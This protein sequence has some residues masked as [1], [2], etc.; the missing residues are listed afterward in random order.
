MLNFQGKKKPWYILSKRFPTKWVK[1]KHGLNPTVQNRGPNVL[2]NPN[3]FSL[4]E[5]KTNFEPNKTKQ[6]RAKSKKMCAWAAAEGES[7]HGP[8]IAEEAPG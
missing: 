8:Q 6:K 3:Y 4:K 2:P 1:G 5:R 7:A